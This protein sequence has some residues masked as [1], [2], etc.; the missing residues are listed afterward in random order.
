MKSKFFSL[1][2]GLSIILI[3]SAFAPTA[4]N[5]IKTGADNPAPLPAITKLTYTPAGEVAPAIVYESAALND[6]VLRTPAIANKSVAQNETDLMFV[7][8]AWQEDDPAPAPTPDKDADIFTWQNLLSAFLAVVGIAFGVYWEK[9]STTLN[10]I[11]AALEDKK[12]TVE[13][14]KNIVSAW[15]G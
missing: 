1:I 10:A 12:V 13:E 9:A 6:Y 5:N 7:Q 11:S 14:I 2:L 3:S 8:A 15:K 4:R